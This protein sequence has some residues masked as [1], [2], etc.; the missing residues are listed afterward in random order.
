M[1]ST[2]NDSAP[3]ADC[4]GTSGIGFMSLLGLLFIAL[5]LTGY[6]HWSWFYVLMPIWIPILL[7]IVLLVVCVWASTIKH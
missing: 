3:P 6:I 2:K 1:N 5:K 4:S 7:T